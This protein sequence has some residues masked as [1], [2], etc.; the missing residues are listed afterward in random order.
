[1]ANWWM[2]FIANPV[3]LES[4]LLQEISLT[5]QNTVIALGAGPHVSAH[6]VRIGAFCPPPRGQL[7]WQ[8][9]ASP[10]NDDICTQPSQ[11]KQGANVFCNHFRQSLCM[12]LGRVVCGFLQ[13]FSL[14]HSFRGLLFPP[15]GWMTKQK[16]PGGGSTTHCYAADWAIQTSA[17]C[18]KCVVQFFWGMQSWPKAFWH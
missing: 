14:Q 13:R 9:E 5:F 2:E 17:H 10:V 4:R 12:Y 7:G 6:H 11:S 1:M 3:T 15:V 18:P 8:C 16:F